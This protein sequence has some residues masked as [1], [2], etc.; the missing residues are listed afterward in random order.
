[1][2]SH[3]TFLIIT[4]LY[5]LNETMPTR[6]DQEINAYSFDGDFSTKDMKKK[7][8]Q[9]LVFIFLYS[10]ILFLSFIACVRVRLLNLKPFF[11][12]I[13]WSVVFFFFFCQC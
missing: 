10:F 9:K 1:M 4:L 11:L 12:S 8:K 13:C 3:K 6:P 5:T 2:Q 7:N